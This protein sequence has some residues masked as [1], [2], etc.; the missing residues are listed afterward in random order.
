MFFFKPSIKLS[1]FVHFYWLFE[2]AMGIE[3]PT[4]QRI[5]P[6]GSIELMFHFGDPIH[7]QKDGNG[8]TNLP[9]SILKGQL[10]SYYDIY[11]RG[12]PHFLSV[13]FKPH[14]ARL[15]FDVPME[16]LL[17][18]NVDLHNIIGKAS[19][20]I[21]DKL[22][23]QTSNSTRIAIVEEFLLSRLSSSKLHNFRRIEAGLRHIKPNTIINRVDLLSNASCL[24]YKQFDRV[25]LDFTGI[26]P[27]QF[28]QIVRFQQLMQ[29]LHE[30]SYRNLT[31]LAVSCGYYD[32]AHCIREVKRLSGY[33]PLQL[34]RQEIPESD[35]FLQV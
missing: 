30:G 22:A 1:D 7:I 6:N 25:F 21:A 3:E 33:T 12:R 19:N 15:F 13:L 14:G 8:N 27:K 5:V 35:L 23:N 2:A 16:K 4:M 9:K 24:S 11:Y 20:E 28:L 29:Q 10:N 18:E 31:D 26:H 32:Q 34:S 17:G